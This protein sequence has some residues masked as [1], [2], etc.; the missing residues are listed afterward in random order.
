MLIVIL[1]SLVIGALAGFAVS[2]GVARMFHAPETQ[3][4]GAFRTLGELNACKGDAVA[5]F[6]FGAGFLLNAAGNMVGAGALTQDVL[7]RL[8]PNWTA[9][10]LLLKNKK[11]EDTLYDPAK[12]GLMGAVVGA[13]VVV[14]LNTLAS[15][16]PASISSIAKNILT[17][18]SN[19][20]INIVM[21]IIFIL[22]ALDAGTI[23][24]IW[25]VVLG[26]IAQL[27]FGNAVP[28]AVL[29]ILIG[30]T[31]Q[32]QGFSKSAKVMLG[33]IC[34]LFIV[35]GIGRGFWAKLFAAFMTFGQYGA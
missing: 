3:A 11:V 30:Q 14:V 4:M 17:P 10:A 8:I 5:H 6:S 22:A 12:M 23:T 34:V 9:G 21:P 24:G 33:I 32:E 25:G 2:A 35:I 16:I 7:H 19:N 1:K 13:I 15:L 27:I 28:G 26:G 29:G 31:I 20:L 18:A